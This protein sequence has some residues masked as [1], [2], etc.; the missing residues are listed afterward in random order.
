MFV[1]TIF[2]S[3]HCINLGLQAGSALY[4]VPVYSV[5][6]YVLCVVTGLIYFDR[7]A[8]MA[9]QGMV[10]AVLFWAGIL[11][12]LS[13]VIVMTIP[14]KYWGTLRDHCCRGRCAQR[15]RTDS[16]SL[17]DPASPA[18]VS[19]NSGVFHIGPVSGSSSDRM[20]IQAP[21]LA[22]GDNGNSGDSDAHKLYN[23]T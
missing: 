7:F 13:G 20:L 21:L 2:V 3:L 11:I 5:L 23:G 18:L 17:N 14:G 16:V 4:F 6:Y 12:A 10:K 1:I 9:E 19:R 22:N 15:P 8:L